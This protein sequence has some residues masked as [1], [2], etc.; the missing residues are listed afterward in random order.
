ME[1][2]EDF[3][4]AEI[5]FGEE[6]RSRHGCVTAWLVFIIVANALVSLIYLMASDRLAMRLPTH[7][8][9]STFLLLAAVGIFNVICAIL[10]LRW[11]IIGFWGFLISG[12]ATIFINLNAGLGIGQALFGLIGVAVLFGILNIQKFG[13]STW[14]QLE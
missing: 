3:G 4:K 5:E 2:N 13:K 8:S 12:I 6:P 11:K 14:E 9:E 7:V 1:Q 10:L